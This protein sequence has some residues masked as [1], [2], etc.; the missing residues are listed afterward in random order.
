MNTIDQNENVWFCQCFEVTEVSWNKNGTLS[1]TFKLSSFFIYSIMDLFYVPVS[2]TGRVNI[3]NLGF[4][5]IIVYNSSF[6]KVDLNYRWTIVS[7]QY[8]FQF[9]NKYRLY[10]HKS[11]YIYLRNKH[12]IEE[13]PELIEKIHCIFEIR[14]PKWV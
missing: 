1:L 12:I 5:R 14:D 13:K 11:E 6:Y 8:L 2:K 9:C 10:F 3:K 4:S 7:I